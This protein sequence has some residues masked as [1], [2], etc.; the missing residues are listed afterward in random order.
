MAVA[1]SL[2]ACKADF[3]KTQNKADRTLDEKAYTVGV[4][5]D[6][7]CADEEA[8][9]IFEQL[10]AAETKLYFKDGKFKSEN[11][12]DI[13]YGEGKTTFTTEYT[14][15]DG[16]LYSVIGYA[17]ASGA[18]KLNKAKAFVSEEQIDKM[19]GEIAF[20]GELS[21]DDFGEATK[22][23]LGGEKFIV[24]GAPSDGAK[25]IL[26]EAMAK[27]LE[28]AS[29]GVELKSA[30]LRIEIEGGK[31]DTVTVE[32]VYSITIQ[33]KAYTV[34]AEIELDFDFDE[35]FDITVPEDAAEYTTTSPENLIG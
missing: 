25:V 16:V 6:F 33:N 19:I 34:E 18:E 32:C 1:L 2:T 14:V 21:S 28:G 15:V 4:E 7:D 31:Y 22:G 27:Q 17:T 9:G 5:Y 30:T 35:S 3:E 26:E 11:V 20:I 13:D 23:E 24:Y 29:E 8:S 12:I 10:E